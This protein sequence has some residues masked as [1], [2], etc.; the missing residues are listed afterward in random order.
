MEQLDRA[1]PVEEVDGGYRI[2]ARCR[3]CQ[4]EMHLE[5]E[6][7]PTLLARAIAAGAM[8]RVVGGLV[9]TLCSDEMEATAE[10]A[11]SEEKRRERL[12]WSNL[13]VPMHGFEFREMV[14]GENRDEAINAARDWA[15]DEKPRGLV[16]FGDVGTGKTR[17]AATAAWQRLRR[18]NVRWVSV[19]VLLAQLGAAFDDKAR[20]EAISVLTGKGALI[21][22]DLDKVNPSE[23]AV[24]Q[25]FAAL[26]T[27][28]QAGAPLLIT[29][30]EPPSGLGAKFGE[31]VMSRVA[32]QRVL[33]LPGQDMRL[34]LDVDT[35]KKGS[36]K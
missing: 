3:S 15:S 13:P 12:T 24:N 28:I 9:C 27:R 17:L 18:W 1:A 23:W 4:V 34:Q 8:P 30:N 2:T 33:K 19:P 36:A 32:E 22:D 25:I 31:P 10:R 26:D 5:S 29:T 14:T 16:I 11:E 21:L 6:E 20:K 35:K 7:E